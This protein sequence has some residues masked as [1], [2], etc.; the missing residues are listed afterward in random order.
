MTSDEREAE[1]QGLGVGARVDTKRCL[2]HQTECQGRQALQ[3]WQ[4]GVQTA[5]QR[6]R[7]LRE[8]GADFRVTGGYDR[9]DSLLTATGK[10]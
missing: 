3:G 10:V 4:A 1:E 5:R 2:L 8:A 9:P 6:D 7:R